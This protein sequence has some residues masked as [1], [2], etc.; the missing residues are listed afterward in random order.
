[1][2]VTREAIED[3]RTWTYEQIAERVN[4]APRTVRSH[5]K[6]P[7]CPLKATHR[8]GGKRF[9]CDTQTLRAYLE[10]LRIERVHADEP[11]AS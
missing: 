8:A 5:T 4:F 1:V 7:T 3:D 6:D 9:A 10:W 2:K 11:R